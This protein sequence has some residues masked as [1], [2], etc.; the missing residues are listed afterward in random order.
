MTRYYR[1]KKDSETG[2]KLNAIIKRVDE[3]TV[4]LEALRLKY[5]FTSTCHY[6]DLLCGVNAVSF[7]KEPDMK[8]WKVIKEAGGYYPRV[9]SANKELRKDFDEI[10]GFAVDRREVDKVVGCEDI[11]AHVGFHWG[12]PDYYYFSSGKITKLPK[13]CEEIPNIEYAKH[14]GE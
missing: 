4:R 7:D 11:F 13:D 3:F 8:S 10:R 5:G 14:V 1:T 12:D 6:T 2:S 9:R